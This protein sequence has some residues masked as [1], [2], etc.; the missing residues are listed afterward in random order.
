MEA[1][2]FS[3]Y[4]GDNFLLRFSVAPLAWGMVWT[5]GMGNGTGM[6]GNIIGVYGE[7]EFHDLR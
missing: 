6:D 1:Y 4:W 7:I 2:S 5:M 3:A